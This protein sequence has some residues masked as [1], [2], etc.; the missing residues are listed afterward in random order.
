MREIGEIM[1]TGYLHCSECKDRGFLEFVDIKALG[2]YFLDHA[3]CWDKPVMLK[4][5]RQWKIYRMIA[6]PECDAGEFIDLDKI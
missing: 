6:C 2:N 5:Y 1:G 3:F 4:L